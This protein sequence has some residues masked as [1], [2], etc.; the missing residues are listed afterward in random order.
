MIVFVSSFEPILSL[1]PTTQLS[2]TCTPIFAF[3]EIRL[4]IHHAEPDLYVHLIRADLQAVTPYQSL[5]GTG[6]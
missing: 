5:P 3:Q 1:V 4:H 6:R 2:N